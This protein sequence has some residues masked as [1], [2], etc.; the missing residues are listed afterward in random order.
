MIDVHNG[1]EVGETGC[2]RGCRIAEKAILPC[3]SDHNALPC[4]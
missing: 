1:L 3:I 4:L 2:E